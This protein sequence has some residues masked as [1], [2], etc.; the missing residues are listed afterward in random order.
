LFNEYTIKIKQKA[1]ITCYY[2]AAT[3]F[4]P[5]T[6]YFQLSSIYKDTATWF[7]I[8]YFYYIS[9]CASVV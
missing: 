2:S 8:W 4:P 9:V 5:A 6:S 1:A 7:Q 3:L